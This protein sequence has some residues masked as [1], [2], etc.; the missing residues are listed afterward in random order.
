VYQNARDGRSLVEPPGHLL[1][2]PDVLALGR[3]RGQR[4]RSG[5]LEC[6]QSRVRKVITER[7]PEHMP[8]FDLALNTGMRRGEMFGLQWP[9]IDFSSRF[10]HIRRGK[11]G[12]GRYVRLNTVALAA[13]V[14]LRRRTEDKGPVIRNLS[15]VPLE[16]AR[17]W[18]EK[19]VVLADVPDF[20]WHDLRHTFASRLAMAG[21]G[22]AAIQRALGHK[23]IAMTMRYA[24]LTEDFMQD[25]VEKIV[26]PAASTSV[27]AET[28][29]RTDTA[30]IG[31]EHQ[32]V[33]GIH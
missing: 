20:R 24:H 9:D 14:E 26:R 5:V 21:A 15:G 16:G 10:A 18:F 32:P 12:H 13:L 8:E 22:I 27:P 3:G 2:G 30:P 25:V 29:S 11:N 19:A 33:P 1:K 4:L 6:V 17:H 31:D 23:S 28:D 7:W